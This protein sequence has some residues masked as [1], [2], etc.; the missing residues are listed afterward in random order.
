MKK[1]KCGFFVDDKLVNTFFSFVSESHGKKLTT[2][3]RLIVI[4]PIQNASFLTNIQLFI[5]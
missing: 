5:S 3:Q 1:K 4:Y 2:D